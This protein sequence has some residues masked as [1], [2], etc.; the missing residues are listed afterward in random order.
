MFTRF[1]QFA[2]KVREFS[3]IEATNKFLIAS[4]DWKISVSMRK[5]AWSLAF[6]NNNV[7]FIKSAR[8]QSDKREKKEI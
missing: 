4:E 1:M 8:N 3:S 7:I 5:S 2:V 6:N